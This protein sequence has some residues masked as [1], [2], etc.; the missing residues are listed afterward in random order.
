MTS[1]ADGRRP[2]RAAPGRPGIV[3][4]TRAQCPDRPRRI[5][6]AFRWVPYLLPHLILLLCIVATL[7]E[8][9]PMIRCT[10][11]LY[12]GALV[13]DVVGEPRQTGSDPVVGSDAEELEKG[14]RV[15]ELLVIAIV[16]LYA[17]F[18]LC[19]LGWMA[20]PE[21]TPL[22]T[23]T[24]L[25]T[26][27]FIG[28]TCAI[29]AA[30]ELLHAKS[31]PRRALS[32][33]VM[34]MLSYPHFS[35]EHLSG[36]HRNVGTVMDAAT[37]RLG[38]SL[39]SFHRRAISWGLI[40]AWTEEVERLHKRGLSAFDFS[41]RLLLY[42][43]IIVAIYTLVG[44]IIGIWGV[45]FVT[46]QGILGS[47]VLESTNYIQHYGLMRTQVSGGSYEPVRAIHA[48]NSS[49]RLS[50]WLLLNLPQHSHHH[51]D[52]ASPYYRLRELS[53]APKL[54][55]GYFALFLVALCPPIWR[56]IMDPRVRA[57]REKYGVCRTN[58]WGDKVVGGSTVAKRRLASVTTRGK[59]R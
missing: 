33:A 2:I 17:V 47:S 46:A 37:A 19:G 35:I 27:G 18:V 41:N 24:V 26:F 23:A 12:L 16:P 28:A 58:P 10:C 50:N 40:N 39:Y 32:G 31:A 59:Q 52:A 56:R 11:W 43:L 29:P 38:E 1:A 22:E 36:H 6:V 20:H 49:H 9:L 7:W 44:W 13:L 21:L 54:P 15:A 3:R 34:L 30:H 48:W 45:L 53:E 5:W 57:L 42:V 51:L 55:M 8:S 14:G 25:V 4:E